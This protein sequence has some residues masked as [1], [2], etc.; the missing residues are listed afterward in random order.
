MRRIHF[1]D[2]P[3]EIG[4]NNGPHGSR[5]H[6]ETEQHRPALQPLRD[7]GASERYNVGART[8]VFHYASRMLTIYLLFNQSTRHLA[9]PHDFVLFN[10]RLPSYR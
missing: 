10:K 3:L 1:L 5:H 8:P 6:P 7:P 4:T 2:A 9:L